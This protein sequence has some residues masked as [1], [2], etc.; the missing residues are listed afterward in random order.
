MFFHACGFWIFYVEIVSCYRVSCT[1]MAGSHSVHLVYSA[2]D[3]I[4]ISNLSK[5]SLEWWMHP[6]VILLRWP[7]MCRAI[8]MDNIWYRYLLG[9]SSSGHFE[10]Y[11]ILL[12]G[13]LHKICWIVP[14]LV[15]WALIHSIH[16]IPYGT[17]PLWCLSSQHQCKGEGSWLWHQCKGAEWVVP[18]RVYNAW[19]YRFSVEVNSGSPLVVE[20]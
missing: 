14:F 6:F 10:V 7:D 3:V 1:S 11:S 15:G 8:Y 12:P 18:V 5:H 4:P 20:Q 13:W 16:G 17:V 2:I 9:K 19:F